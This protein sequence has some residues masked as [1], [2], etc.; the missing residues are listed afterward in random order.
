M[1][2]ELFDLTGKVAL[3][4]GGGGGLGK[5]IS[6]GLAKAGAD[7]IPVSRS[8]DRTKDVVEE[9]LA[10]GRKSL[11]TSVDVTDQEDVNRLVEQVIKEFGRIDILINAAGKNYKKPALEL[12]AEEWDDVMAVNVKGTFL[13]CKAVG[14]KMLAQKSGKIINIASLGSHQG[15]TRSVAYCASKGAVLQL[16]KVLSAE[17][18]AHGVNVNCISPGYFKTP[19]TEKILAVK[20]THDKIVSRTPMQRLGL[21]EDLVGAAI[22]LSSDASNFITGSTIAV[23]GGF[24]SLAI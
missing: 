2:K 19:L 1:S 24:L 6:I 4:V 5:T 13:A 11:H 10:L 8:K 21:P 15:I 9:I 16:T 22:F 14:E 12:T 23:E 3:F 7:V 18:A 20:E 17:W